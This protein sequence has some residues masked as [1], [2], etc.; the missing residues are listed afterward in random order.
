MPQ[1]LANFLHAV[2]FLT[3]LP[4]N[5][6]TQLHPQ[7]SNTFVY[8]P[9]V[10]LVLGLLLVPPVVAHALLTPL[11]LRTAY[12]RQQGIA[13]NLVSDMPSQ[14]LWCV[15]GAS[16]LLVLS[17]VGLKATAM[18]LILCGLSYCAWRY[19]WQQRIGGFTSDTAG[20]FIEITELTALIALAIMPRMN[21][22]ITQTGHLILNGIMGKLSIGLT[23]LLLAISSHAKLSVIDA[24]GN[25]VSLDVPAKR[26]IA[27]APHIV[28]NTYSAGAGDKLVAAVAYADFPESAKK[29]PHVG[30]YKTFN[31]E[32]IL[33]LKPD[34][35]LAWRSGNGDEIVQRLK[36]LGIPVY[37]SEP[38]TLQDIPL[39]LQDIGLLAGTKEIADQEAN[40]YLKK[41]A[42]LRQ[43]YQAAVPVS[44]FYQ[45]WYQPLQ[46]LNDEHLISDVIRLCGG[47][48]VFADA[49]SLAPKINIE[50][51]VQRNPQAIV[52]SGM[53]EA[54]PDWLDNWLDW[55]SL[56]A[57]KNNHLFFVPPDIVQRHTVRIMQGAELLCEQ[58]QQVRAASKPAS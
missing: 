49:L 21:Q 41:L 2:Q 50:A 18:L 3:T 34:L 29:L 45:V 30:T 53:G 47:N 31:L 7:K 22:P 25:T 6:C 17:L 27:L 19:F 12:S 11:F 24:D 37:V 39:V 38:K 1:P 14:A 57:V 8:H 48:N 13:S 42:K 36:G 55:P 56:Q 51:V 32:S 58:L 28:E 33:A 44:V 16:W 5:H 20:A 4:V 46:T 54:R 26:I 10:G 35:I 23:L 43:T 9:A 15:V 40:S 52:A